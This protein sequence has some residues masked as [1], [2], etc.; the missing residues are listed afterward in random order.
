MRSSACWITTLWHDT[1]SVWFSLLFWALLVLSM[2]FCR[3][4]LICLVCPFSSPMFLVS[5]WDIRSRSLVGQR[6]CFTW[7][8]VIFVWL[9]CYQRPSVC[10]ITTLWNGTKSVWFPF[11]FW[12][13]LKISMKLCRF[14]FIWKVVFL[15]VPVF[16][17][18]QWYNSSRSSVGQRNLWRD[19]R[20][21]SF[22][23]TVTLAHL[24]AG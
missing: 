1:Q 9:Q 13:H 14:S 21:F 5:Q 7:W 22:D 15:P 19:V 8:P 11:H 10:W 16:L 12:A 3:F 24:L 2:N 6:W 23:C 4:W 20:Y 17:V 18:S